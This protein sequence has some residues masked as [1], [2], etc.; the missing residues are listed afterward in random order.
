MY[1]NLH[2]RRNWKY[3]IDN[4]IDREL[5]FFYVGNF[6]VGHALLYPALCITYFVKAVW[7]KKLLF[8]IRVSLCSYQGVHKIENTCSVFF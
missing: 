2:W 5:Q 6:A 4:F 7:E 3:N 8:S 1:S